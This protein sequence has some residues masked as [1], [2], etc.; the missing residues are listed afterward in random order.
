MLLSS[1][2]AIIIRNFT[3]DWNS[4]LVLEGYRGNEHPG[5]HNNETQVAVNKSGEPREFGSPIGRER[6]RKEERPAH[7]IILDDKPACRLA[8]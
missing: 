1:A 2:I 5:A 8:G 7:T 6:G 4:P 3:C